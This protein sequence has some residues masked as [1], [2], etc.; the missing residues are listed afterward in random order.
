MLFCT[1]RRAWAIHF[2][3]CG[4]WSHFRCIL[5]IRYVVSNNVH[6][7]LRGHFACVFCPT[8]CVFQGAVAVEE[9]SP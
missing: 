6:F 2:S 4:A 1:H 8:G 9:G 5:I 3:G 7:I